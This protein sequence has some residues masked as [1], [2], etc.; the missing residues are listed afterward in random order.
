MRELIEREL[1]EASSVLS[2]FISDP[3]N[4]AS[5]EAAA[6][7]MIDCIKNGHKIITCGNGGSF[8]D[9]M[10]FAQELTGVYRAKR[11]A[12]PALSICDGSHLTCAANDYG[13]D[14]I[15]SRYVEGIGV[16]GDVLLAISTSGN[17]KN[18]VEAI[19]VAR[20]RGLKV[21]SLT[22]RGGGAVGPISDVEVRVPHQGFTDRIQEV[23]IKVIHILIMLI[24][25]GVGVSG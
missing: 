8:C 13:V 23:H 12:L 14:Q 3:Q 7:V 5:I 22:G 24:E 2:K 4:I 17:S 21:V 11:R 20:G 1:E 10:H 16:Q 9:A 25:R 19:N 18:V 6:G 15:F